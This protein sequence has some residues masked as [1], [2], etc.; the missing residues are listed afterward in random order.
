MNETSIREYITRTFAGVDVVDATGGSFFGKV[1]LICIFWIV[2]ML[3]SASCCSDDDPGSRT[4]PASNL[5]APVEQFKAKIADMDAQQ[6]LE[7]AAAQF[8]QPS[9]NVGSGLS[10]PQWDIADGVVTVHPLVGPTFRRADKTTWLIPTSNPA[11]ENLL[12]DFEITTLPDPKNHGTQLWIGTVR[13]TPEGTYR[14]EDGG[15][16]LRARGDQSSNFFMSHTEGHVEIIWDLGVHAHSH[17]ENLGHRQIA[18]LRF[19]SKYGDSRLEC[20]VSSSAESRRL[21]IIASSFEMNAGWLHYW[22]G[23]KRG[24]R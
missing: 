3:G 16:N 5:P 11:R 4:S 10:I 13:I 12:R 14:F 8:G 9:R 2:G 17:L 18:R 7:A 21:S 6:V 15:S 20:S 22:S 1:K 24:R 19:T 23:G